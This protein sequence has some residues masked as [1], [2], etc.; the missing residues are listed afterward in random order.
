MNRRE[1]PA[2]REHLFTDRPG[3][4]IPTV[5]LPRPLARRDVREIAAEGSGRVEGDREAEVHELIGRAAAS[6]VVIEPVH[7]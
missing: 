1:Q 3:L 5:E 2:R 7:A 6:A 4:A